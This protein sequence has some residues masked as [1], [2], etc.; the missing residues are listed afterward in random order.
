MKVNWEGVYPAVTTKFHADG[1]LD[2]PG[3]NHNLEAQIQA[4]IDA[5]V[6]AGSLGE[7]STL[8]GEDKQK[9]LKSAIDLSAGRVPVLLNIAEKQTHEAIRIAKEAEANGANGLMLLPPMQYKADERE[10][11]AFFRAVAEST[12]LPIMLYNNPVDYKILISISMLEA[13]KDCANIQAVKESSRDIT[14]VTRMRNAFGDR[15]K[16]L[17]G[18]DT[19]ALE[20]IAAGADGWVAGLVNAFPRETV[21]IYKLVKAGRIA[22]ALSIYRWFM[23]LLELD[24]HPKLVQ[25]IKLAEVA[26]GLGTEMVRPPRLVLEG[27]EREEV[28]AIIDRGVSSRPDMKVFDGL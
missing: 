22:E 12:Q 3:F 15:F 25:Y 19:L 20:C 8:S 14:N 6:I 27:S 4:G 16:I 11:I 1:S 17:C 7:A 23:P 26:T 5:I 10:C 9:L 28:T 24:I 13:L 18:V 21:V 2:L